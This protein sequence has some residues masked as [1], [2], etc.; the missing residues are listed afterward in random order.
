[1]EWVKD[2]RLVYRLAVD[3]YRGSRKLQLIAEHLDPL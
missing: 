3:E 1:V 2:V